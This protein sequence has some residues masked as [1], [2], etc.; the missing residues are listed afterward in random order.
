M[1]WVNTALKSKAEAILEASNASNKEEV[2]LHTSIQT[3]NYKRPQ[4]TA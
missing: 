3:S 1:F 2:I 4:E